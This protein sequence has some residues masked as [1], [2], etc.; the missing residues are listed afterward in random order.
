LRQRLAAHL[1]SGA[2]AKKEES[3]RMTSCRKKT[4]CPLGARLVLIVVAALSLL[5]LAVAIYALAARKLIGPWRTVY[6]VT[7][8]TILYLNFFVLVA[9][10]FLHTPCAQGIGSDSI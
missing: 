8:H 3:G 7:A 1:S 2:L 9:Q 5:L 4:A 6:V 10:L